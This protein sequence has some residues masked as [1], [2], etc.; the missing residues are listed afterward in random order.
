MDIAGDLLLL[1]QQLTAGGHYQ[2]IPVPRIDGVVFFV[3]YITNTT[4]T[5]TS[6]ASPS[7]TTAASSTS[8]TVMS[9]WDA[10]ARTFAVHETQ[11]V[12]FFA[13]S[14]PVATQA[15]QPEVVHRIQVSMALA[16]PGGDSSEFEV[17]F[18]FVQ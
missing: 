10:T 2:D 14:Y 11:A 18:A 13:D 4:T 7:T 9:P 16:A 15:D 6:T 8:T 3:E 1:Q 17:S 12:K 5:A